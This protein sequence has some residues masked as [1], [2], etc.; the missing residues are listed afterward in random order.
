MEKH[1]FVWFI[2]HKALILRKALIDQLIFKW[3]FTIQWH[4]LLW[5]LIHPLKLIIIDYLQEH[6]LLTTEKLLKF[7]SE[8]H[9]YL[10]LVQRVHHVYKQLVDQSE[11]DVTVYGVGALQGYGDALFR[12]VGDVVRSDFG[13]VM[14]AVGFIIVA[15]DCF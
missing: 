14:V 2:N 3:E 15:R 10:V 4:F 13:L 8:I 6:H 12:V 1:V 7:G 11:A 5:V 9:V